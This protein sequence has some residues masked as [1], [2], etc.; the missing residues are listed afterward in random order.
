MT[1]FAAGLMAVAGTAMCCAGVQAQTLEPPFDSSYSVFDVGS[2]PGLP[3]PY[4]GLTLLRG[5][6]DTLLIGGSANFN[7]A[8]VFSVPL[9]RNIC[10]NIVGFASDAMFFASAPNIDGGLTYGPD[11]VLFAAA[12]PTNSVHQIK[13]GSTSPDRTIDVGPLIGG[14]FSLGSIMFV[15]D[16]L[17][18]AGRLK[19]ATYSTGAFADTT[20]TPDGSGTFDI[21]PGTVTTTFNGGPEG[22]VYVPPGSPLFPNPTM[23]VALYNFGRVDAVDVDANGNPIAGTDR[24]FLTGLS[25]V[26]GAFI[27]PQSGDFI[28]S[29]YGGGNRIVSVRGFARHCDAIDFNG[30]G[31]YP[32][33]A[34]IDDFL[35]VFSGGSCS[36]GTCGDIDFNNDCLFPD[37]SDIDSL[38]SVFSGGPCL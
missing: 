23:L 20:V 14:H 27:D 28:F 25:G 32:D 19:L 1:K 12:Y 26:E 10:E 7:S 30:D 22:I 35:S 37:T 6:P 21:N 38:L 4:G 34:D 13:P 36:T 9:T 16:G 24:P 8:A 18:G 11:G 31:L 15:P 33:T 29:T 3:A 5:D 17:G 2:V